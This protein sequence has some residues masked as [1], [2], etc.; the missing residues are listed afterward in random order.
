M[1]DAE[2]RNVSVIPIRHNSPVSNDNEFVA[3]FAFNLWLALAF[4]DSPEHALLTSMEI[5]RGQTRAALS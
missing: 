3:D 1:D 5:V 2:R 4:R